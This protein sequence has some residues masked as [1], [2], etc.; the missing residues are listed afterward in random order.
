LAS[1]LRSRD[2]GAS[3][4]NVASG[5][6]EDAMSKSQISSEPRDGYHYNPQLGG[7]APPFHKETPQSAN[8]SDQA[9]RALQY[10]SAVITEHPS[11]A[12]LKEMLSAFL[13]ALSAY[14]ET[15]DTSPAE[16]ARR[17]GQSISEIVRQRQLGQALRSSLAKGYRPEDFFRR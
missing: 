10:L 13:R 1:F 4:G 3:L 9:G 15:I 17:F 14:T 11:D 2:T 8:L 12:G 7:W 5:A 6:S 16:A